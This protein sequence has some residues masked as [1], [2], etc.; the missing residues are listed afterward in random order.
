M[1]YLYN[2]FT[3]PYVLVF[4]ALLIPILLS[5]RMYPVI[6]Y[7]VKSKNLMDEPIDRSMHT[8]KTPTLGGV[9]MFITF[10]LTLITDH[11][12]LLCLCKNCGQSIKEEFYIFHTSK[13]SSKSFYFSIK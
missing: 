9:G 6:I 7:L 8:A 13:L 3:N 11:D 2:L 12:Q 5:L 10:S 4:V 1:A